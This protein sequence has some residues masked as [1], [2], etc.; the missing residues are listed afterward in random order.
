MLLSS[1][2]FQVTAL[3]G[4]ESTQ[5]SISDKHNFY[6]QIKEVNQV[7]RELEQ[8]KRKCVKQSEEWHNTVSEKS[9]IQNSIL[10]KDYH[11]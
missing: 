4:E 2:Q 8:I 3:K 7:N 11:L 9:M 1:E 5:Q 10:Y 6:K